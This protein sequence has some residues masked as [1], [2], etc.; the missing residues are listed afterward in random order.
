MSSIRQTGQ[1]GQTEGKL[2]RLER[3]VRELE[4]VC[5]AVEG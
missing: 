3:I 2:G 1:T 4:V 5:E